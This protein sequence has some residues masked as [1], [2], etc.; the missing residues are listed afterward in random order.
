MSAQPPRYL[1]HAA[2][3]CVVQNILI[4]GIKGSFGVYAAEQPS[5]AL[6]FM[7]FRLLDHAHRL[8]EPIADDGSSYPLTVT[9][10]PHDSIHVWKIDT[11]KTDLSKWTEGTD[12]STSFFGNATSWVYEADLVPADAIMLPT[13]FSREAIL[14]ATQSVGT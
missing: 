10:V 13:V 6:T 5:H 1:Y 8:D 3:E 2:P 4:E 7:W 14:G 11:R 12:H 9:L